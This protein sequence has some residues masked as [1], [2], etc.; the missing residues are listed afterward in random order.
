MN[1]AILIVNRNDPKRTDA[2]VERCFS[3]M[4]K[5]RDVYVIESGSDLDKL[6]KYT[7]VWVK[8]N[9]NWV[10]GFNILR[11][12]A[13]K[14]KWRHAKNYYDA[15]HMICND[16]QFPEGIDPWTTMEKE[17]EGC[18]NWGIAHPYQLYFTKGHPGYPLNKQYSVGHRQ[19]S[20]VEFVC[21]LFN[22][23]LIDKCPQIIDEDF[24]RGW[25]IDYLMTYWAHKL[26]YKIYNI[27]TVGTLHIPNTSHINHT[28]TKTEDQ[29]T[30]LHTARVEMLSVLTAKYGRD[31]GDKFLA[32]IPRELKD[33]VF[34]NWSVGDRQ[35]SL[36]WRK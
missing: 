34:R 14:H 2:L 13:D 21:P 20:F 27:D 24:T 17:L 3:L 25:G 30:F 29:S 12:Y 33:D 7:S 28:Q 9:I 6:S 10:Q 32:Q 16:A 8:E 18:P 19:V 15:Y 5:P 4:T 35:A 26:D 22:R 31:W 36:T 11:N 1:I 23:N